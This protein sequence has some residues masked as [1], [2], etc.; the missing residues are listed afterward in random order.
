MQ[1]KLPKKDD[2]GQYLSYSAMSCFNKE[3]RKFIREYFLKEPRTTNDYLLFGNKVGQALELNDF[4]NFSPKEKELLEK[5]PRLDEFER[6]INLWF[7]D[8]GFRIMGF[9]DTADKSLKELIDYKTTSN[10][11]SKMAQYSEPD[12]L[13]LVIYGMAIEQ[14]T[15]VHPESIKIIG[16][17][18]DGNAFKG[19][20]L[21]VGDRIFE[22]DL[23]ISP[24]RKKQAEDYIIKTAQEVTKYTEIFQK[25][26]Q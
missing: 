8:L 1:I 21:T 22:L 7:K 16:I 2:K 26:N 25:L 10:D 18:R 5:V 20:E 14:E 17:G 9:I 24:E 4:S 15:G 12:Y 6:P 3:R 23:E 11:G 19:E 13:Q